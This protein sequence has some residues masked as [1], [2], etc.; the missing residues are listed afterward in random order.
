MS[1]HPYLVCLFDNNGYTSA[2]VVFFLRFDD[3]LSFFRFVLFL[4]KSFQWHFLCNR[5]LLSRFF[6]VRFAFW[7]KAG[8]FYRKSEISCIFVAIDYR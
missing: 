8:I 6:F 5:L 7:Q 4:R 2:N 3:S 1:K